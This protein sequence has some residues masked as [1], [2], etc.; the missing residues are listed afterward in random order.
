MSSVPLRRTLLLLSALALSACQAPAVNHDFDAGRDFGAYRSWTWKTPA[1]RYQPDD[2]RLQSDLT[3]QRLRDAVNEQLDQRGLR[4]AAAGNPPGLD[5]QTYLIV[6]N[7]QQQ[8]T[9]SYGGPFG[10]VWGR[11]WGGGGMIETR[12][13]D[14][15]VTT[16][17]IDL[18]DH[19]DGKLVWRGSADQP[20]L[21]DSATPDQRTT[22]VRTTVAKILSQY[23]PH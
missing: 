6:E 16:L 13:L 4:I 8:V 5:V 3:E 9:T 11:P 20:T 22:A 2:P 17:Q 12:N 18:Y 15:Q 7:R 10:P 1:L 21:G 23:P 14:Y 19:K